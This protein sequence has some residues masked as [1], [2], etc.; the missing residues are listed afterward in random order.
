VPKD[1]LALKGKQG[2]KVYKVKLVRQDRKQI[3]D[4]KVLQGRQGLKVY[5]EPQ[6]R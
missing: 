3:Q 2:P 5:K 1:T 6:A 4:L